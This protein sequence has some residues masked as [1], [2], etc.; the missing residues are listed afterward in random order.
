MNVIRQN[1]DFFSAELVLHISK[2]NL[3]GDKCLHLE[4]LKG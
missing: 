2:L 4:W 3:Y 1:D